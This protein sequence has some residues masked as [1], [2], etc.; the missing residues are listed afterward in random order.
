MKNILMAGILFCIP[1]IGFTQDLHIYYDVYKDSIFYLK[2]G[3]VVEKANLKK[4]ARTVLHLIN[5]NDYI[6]QVEVNTKTKNYNIPSSGAGKMFDLSGAGDAFSNLQNAAGS[7]GA[8]GFEL[9]S[10]SLT[11][12]RDGAVEYESGVSLEAI[13]LSKKFENVLKEM[14]DIEEEIEELAEDI[15]TKLED[16]QFA[17]FKKEEAQKLRT[18]PNLSANMIKQISLDYMQQILGVEAGEAFDLEKMFEKA[19]PQNTIGAIIK[20]YKVE[21]NR[22]ETKFSELSTIAELLFAFKLAPTDQVSF[23]SAFLQAEKRKSA[24]EE[25]VNT[26]EEQMQQIGKWDIREFSNIRYLYEEMKDHRFEKKLIFKPEDDLTQIDIRLI[27]IDSVQIQ[28]VR[29]KTL[30]PLEV[31]VFGGLKINASVGISF[32]GF[33]TRPQ[34]YFV[35]EGR[36]FADDLDAFTPI[37]TSFVHFHPQS[38]KQVSLGGAFGIG[39]GIGGESSGLQNY[40]LGPSVIVGKSQRIVFSTGLMTGKLQ[41]L[42]QG[43]RVGDSYD[44]SIIPTKSIYEMGYFLGVSFNF[45]G[46]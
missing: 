25:K 1:L 11:N 12:E 37:I 42:S 41:R 20:D 6:Y 26:M 19:N 5:Y 29:T 24:Y 3:Q 27:P 17:A 38:K 31:E 36:I 18:N 16:Q 10:N 43:Y 34:N 4:G 2:N 15:E 23:E 30:S 40:F 14:A 46:K 44:E 32:A 9:G 8:S 7:F 22:L 33:F 35:R 28:G 39:I 21:T 13:Q 45:M